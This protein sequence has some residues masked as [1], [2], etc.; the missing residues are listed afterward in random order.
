MWRSPLTAAGGAAKQPLGGRRGLPAGL[1][2][3]AVDGV[4]VHGCRSFAALALAGVFGLLRV[5]VRAGGLEAEGVGRVNAGVAQILLLL[6]QVLQNAELGQL[7]V[8]MRAAL[9]V[10]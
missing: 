9:Q 4:P 6:V 10:L 2:V 5:F 7:L 3:V 1:L 8:L